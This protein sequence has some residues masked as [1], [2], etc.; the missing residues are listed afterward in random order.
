MR[1]LTHLAIKNTTESNEILEDLVGSQLLGQLEVLDLSLGTLTDEGAI[2]MS[3]FP[4]YDSLKVIVDHH[5]CSTAVLNKLKD[6]LMD[7][8]QETNQQ[9]PPPFIAVGE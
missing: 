2:Y 6:D 5:F 8:F 4:C 1:S 9:V 3:T 7:R